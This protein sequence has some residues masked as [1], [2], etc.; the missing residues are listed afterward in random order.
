MQTLTLANNRPD[1]KRADFRPK[2][3]GASAIPASVCGHMPAPKGA[4]TRQAISAYVQHRLTLEVG[5]ERGKAAEIASATGTSTA[6]I[7]NMKNRKANAGEVFSRAIAAYWQI[8]YAELER[9]ALAWAKEQP[10]VVRTVEISDRYPN[11]HIAAE[12]A[13]R[14]GIDSEA[15][16]MVLQ[17]A[18]DAEEDPSPSTWLAMIKEEAIVLRRARSAPAVEAKK[19]EETNAQKSDEMAE[20]M[21]PKM[22]KKATK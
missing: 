15:I 6:H 10:A 13:R 3:V 12:F 19:R 8:E 17:S 18:H 11:R 7:A 21:R 16:A 4:K 14:D 22:P 20:E 1:F 9:L 5:K 2:L